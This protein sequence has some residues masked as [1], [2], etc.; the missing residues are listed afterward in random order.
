MRISRSPC[1]DTARKVRE[2]DHGRLVI[3]LGFTQEEANSL[4]AATTPEV[5]QLLRDWSKGDESALHKLMPLVERELH[6]LAR[7][8]MRSEKRDHT[9]RATALLNE[10]YLRLVDQEQVQWKN[11]SH[12]LA[13]SAQLMRRI[14]VDHAR[15]RKFA[16]R[17]GGAV[18]VSLDERNVA[19][20]Q[21]GADL[22]ALDE[23]LEKLAE[24]DPRKARV[25]ELRFF[26]GLDFEEVA[27]AL[28]VSVPTVKRDWTAARS[29]LYTFLSDQV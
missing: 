27:E 12:F 11:Q 15:K 19:S 1:R 17:G 18:E 5:T 20:P 8:Y 6:R 21:R 2:K 14:L 10:V 23:A 25:V 3:I 22:V 26:G 28:S 16:K 9:L 13:L 29:W 24:I 7:R 4:T